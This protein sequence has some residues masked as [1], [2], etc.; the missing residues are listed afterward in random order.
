MRPSNLLPLLIISALLFGFPAGA[1]ASIV[2]Q[3]GAFYS[4]TGHGA[5]VT[6]LVIHHPTSGVE[7]GCVAWDGSSRVIGTAVCTQYYGGS[8]ISGGGEQNSSNSPTIL[9]SAIAHAADLA[10]IFNPAESNAVTLEKLYLT[11]IGPSGATPLFTAWLESPVF[12][13]DPGPGT[14]GSGFIFKLDAEQADL[15]ETFWSPGNHLALAALISGAEAGAES[16]YVTS[17]PAETEIPEPATFLLLG[18]G[19]T[20]LGAA[21]RRRITK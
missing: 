10:I 5:V 18:S 7:S 15:A 19:L 16:F 21:L 2:F 17:I 20:I 6:V 14:G 11:I 8:G 1:Y 12:F 13:S 3:E 4:G 9:E